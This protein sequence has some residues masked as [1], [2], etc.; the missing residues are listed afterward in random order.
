MSII[1]NQNSPNLQNLSYAQIQRLG[2]RNVSNINAPINI[3]RTG[4]RNFDNYQTRLPSQSQLPPQ[5][6]QQAQQSTVQNNA[7]YT[8]VVQNSNECDGSV[9]IQRQKISVNYQATPWSLDPSFQVQP[10]YSTLVPR[11]IFNR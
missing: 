11:T 5:L 8:G 2:N 7:N 4:I 3:T 6:P 1:Q 10:E 9:K